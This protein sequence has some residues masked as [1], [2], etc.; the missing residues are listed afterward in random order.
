MSSLERLDIFPKTYDD[1]KERTLGGALISIVCCLLALCLFTAEF[2][3]YRA[4]ETVDR[5]DV[6]TRTA[7]NS[8]LSINLD[9]LL[10]SLP[11]DEIVMD[12]VDESGSEQLAVTN[13]LH[14]LR[15]DRHGVPIDTPEAVD[16]SHTLAPAFHQRKV[17]QLMDDAHLH[18]AETLGHLQHEDEENPGLDEQGHEAH[19]EE[20]TTQAAL[21]QCRLAHLTAVAEEAEHAEVIGDAAH[22]EHLAMTTQE[23]EALHA[24]ITESQAY[25]DEQREQVLSNLH[26][27]SRN[28]NRLQSM[29]PTEEK[30]AA[31]L[32][33]AL[34]IRLSILQDNVAGFVTAADIDRRDKYA[35]VEQ[36]L[37]DVLNV[38]ESLTGGM[39]THLNES[40]RAVMADLSE[41]SEGARGTRRAEIETKLSSHLAMLQA[42]LRGEEVTPE[43][44]CGSCYGASL[45]VT[46]CCN[47]CDDLRAA[48]R[49][50]KWG[51]PG[52]AS[53]DQCRREKQRRAQRREEGEG[54][55]VYGTMQVARV[56][57]SFHIA[58]A[59]KA[60]GSTLGMLLVPHRVQ[61]DEVGHFNVS[62]QIKRLSFGT[63][64][65]GQTNPLDAAFTHS[66]S[67]AAISRYFLKVVP[68]TYEFLS[69]EVVHTNQFSVTSY[70]KPIDIDHTK[71]VP[72]TITFTFELTPIKVRKTERRG[73]SLLGFFTRCA[74][75]IGGLFTVAGIV[76][77]SL[78]HSSKKLRKMQEGRQD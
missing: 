77:A 73:G 28:L 70:F 13:T 5:L 10:P 18:L 57:G 67:G 40:V 33:E 50:R 27:M 34:R 20:L 65:P 68:T 14:K 29:G 78:Y 48:Y 9:L 31:N 59:S 36:I 63:D 62:H 45:D 43:G 11:C 7:A 24:S 69:G 51:F 52:E 23:V 1:F 66:P 12:V 19:R 71:F 75:L 16:W 55:N 41:L 25:S 56:T 35:S 30:T 6:D 38:S 15:V 49:Q 54:C 76:D 61:P 72:P 64:Y 17:I 21:L 4:V 26:A 46:A 60:T 74:A 58:P 8:K 47:S 32:R 42:D 44:Y 2:A 3:Q 37:G 39:G 53:F 22:Q